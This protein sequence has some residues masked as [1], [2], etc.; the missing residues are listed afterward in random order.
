MLEIRKFKPE[1][2]Q[3]VSRIMFESFK[4]FLGNMMTDDKPLPPEHYIQNSYARNEQLW[5]QGFTAL[6]DDKVIG[7]ISVSA[8][9]RTKLGSLGVI[10]VDPTTMAHGAGTALFKAAYDFWMEAGVNKIYTCTSS[11]NTRAQRYYAKMGFSEEGRRKNHFYENVDELSLVIYP[12][13]KTAEAVD[14]EIR[15]MANK[16]VEETASLLTHS[17]EIRGWGKTRLDNFMKYLSAVSCPRA[18]V[19]ID[20]NTKKIIGAIASIFMEKYQ[21]AY[22]QFLY[23]DPTWRNKGIGTALFQAAV[24]DWSTTIHIRK[25]AVSLPLNAVGGLPFLLHRGFIVEEALTD[26]GGPGVT[27][28]NLGRFFKE[29]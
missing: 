13:R 16:D 3:E 11:I 23:V 27:N 12:H 14:L 9:L 18:L 8:D 20:P 21:L 22:M 10:G 19:A 7:Y 29:S 2:A 4:T 28:I 24:A 25:V 15:P 26:Q 5:R 6:D 1:D 17:D